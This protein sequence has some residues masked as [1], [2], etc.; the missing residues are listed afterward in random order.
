VRESGEPLH[1]IGLLSDGNVHSHRIT[2]SRCSSA[3]TR[4]REEGAGARAARRPR[5]AR[6]ERARVR[7]RLE[8]LLE[9]NAQAL[10]RD[11]RV[12]SGGGRMKVTMDR[13]EADW[14]MVER[15]WAL[16]VRGEGRGFASLREAIETLRDESPASAIR[17]SRA[18]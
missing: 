12:A 7:R 4:G 1:F 5:R 8:A 15:G 18:S 13:Y 17:T 10:G 2:C 6:D 16:H 14:A 11:Y 9:I 3:P